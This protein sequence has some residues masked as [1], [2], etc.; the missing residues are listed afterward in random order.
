MTF[1]QTDQV[2]Q[3]PA[4]A[5][6]TGDFD[7]LRG[8]ERSEGVYNMPAISPWMIRRDVAMAVGGFDPKVLMAEDRDLDYRLLHYLRRMKL[9]DAMVSF[10]NLYGYH[11]H[12][13]NTGLINAL[14]TAMPIME[15]RGRRLEADAQSTEDCLPTRLDDLD[16][17][18]RDMME[19]KRPPVG[20]QYRKDWRGKIRRRA[21]RVWNALTGIG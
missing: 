17:L 8:L 12:H 5:Y 14:D 3:K 20:N 13:A 7:H 16:A 4:A 9:Q 21:R 19:T 18:V 11:Q 10:C 6:G 15:S 2:H 1:A